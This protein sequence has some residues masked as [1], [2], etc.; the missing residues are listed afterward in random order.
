M[1]SVLN[2][3]WHLYIMK[4]AVIPRIFPCT[5]ASCALF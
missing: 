1:C 2:G 5:T 3:I 4:N